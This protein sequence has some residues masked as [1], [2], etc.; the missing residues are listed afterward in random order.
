MSA[1]EFLKAFKSWNIVLSSDAFAALD[2]VVKGMTR[3]E[4]SSL[5]DKIIEKIERVHCMDR[6]TFLSFSFLVQNGQT[7]LT[8]TYL[9]TL[10]KAIQEIEFTG[11]VDMVFYI[12]LEKYPLLRYNLSLKSFEV[13]SV[14]ACCPLAYCQT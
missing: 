7:T 5:V 6:G 11:Q 2:K 14:T 4:A 12:E 13:R 9:E 3:T 10:V 1:R 8:A